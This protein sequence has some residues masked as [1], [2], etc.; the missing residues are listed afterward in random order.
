MDEDELLTTAEAA[1]I[2]RQEPGT[3]AQWRYLGTGPF[4]YK[5]GRKPLYQRSELLAWLEKQKR[6]STKPTRT[7]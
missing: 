7:D 4:Y 2:L 6:T 3:L 5:S 1:P